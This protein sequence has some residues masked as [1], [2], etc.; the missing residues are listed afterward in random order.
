MSDL[1]IT[2]SSFCEN[3]ELLTRLKDVGFE[4]LRLNS[5]GDRLNRNELV[6]LLKDQTVAIVG[7][8]TVDES[9]LSDCP[10]LKLISKF[11]VGLDNI[12]KSACERHGVIIGF[13]PG[14]NSRSVAEQT[15][16]YMIFLFRN[17]HRTSRA[18]RSGSWKK[19]GGTQLSG[20][21]VGVIGV[22]H[23][24]KD[25][26]QLLQPFGCRIIANDV[27]DQSSYFETVN[28][29]PMEKLQ[30]YREA[31]VLTL[32]TPLDH[33]TR[34]L[35]NRTVF[36]TMKSSAF[37]INTARGEVVVQEDL[38]WAL[39]NSVIAGAGIDVYESEPPT[40]LEL[41]EQDNLICTPHVGG[42]A[43]ESVLKMGNAAIDHV[44]RFLDHG[45]AS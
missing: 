28:V 2:S 3:L 38:K 25:L 1:A 31:D 26:I 13:T 41:L 45:E 32:H 9:L 4:S 24:G 10:S 12:D 19:S 42:N 22:G 21:T 29:E 40:D 6:A 5:T 20:K 39:Q 7:T 15:L 23:V 27:L 30:V 36:E 37:L 18:L 14:T 11:G 35:I 8:D 16:G 43:R 44:L 33:S 34:A 17:L